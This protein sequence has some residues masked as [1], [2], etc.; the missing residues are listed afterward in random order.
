MSDSK[1]AGFNDVSDTAWY[2]DAVTFIAAHGITTGTSAGI[3][4][5]DMLLTRG[6][7]M[8]M[9]LRAYGIAPVANPV[10]NFTDAGSTYYTG[11]LAAAKKFGISQGVGN[12][13]FAPDMEITRQEMF[14]LLYNALKTVGKLP[15]TD[16]GKT[17]SDFTD[18]SQIASWATDSISSLVKTGS[19]VGCGGL[20]NPLSATTRAEM[21]QVLYNLLSK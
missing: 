1:K 14:T 7:F 12:N 5:P 20:L 2:A 4:S 9:L 21:A 11:Y 16:T 13:M 3:F 8:V 10:D 19:I 18:A 6:Q 17:L 15:T